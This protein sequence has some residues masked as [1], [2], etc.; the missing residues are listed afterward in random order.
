M[1]KIIIVILIVLGIYVIYRGIRH[2]T[3]RP[4]TIPTTPTESV[5]TLPEGWSKVTASTGA[6]QKYEKVVTSGLKPE[7]V[8]TETTSTDATNSAKYSNLLIAGAKSALPSL[9][10]LTDETKTTDPIFSRFLSGYYYNQKTKVNLLQRIYIEGES[11]SVLTA[12]YDSRSANTTEINA[13]FDSIWS[14]R[15][16]N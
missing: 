4:Q 12:S 15:L 14:Q 2:F 11:T 9:R 10:Y 16:P 1:K 13:I 6:S 8:L 3:Y 7:I 5:I